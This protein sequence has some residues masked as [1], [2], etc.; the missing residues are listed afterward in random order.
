MTDIF[1][2]VIIEKTADKAKAF[3]SV[4]MSMGQMVEDVKL[5]V[6]GKAKVDFYG[7]TG[8]VIPLPDEILGKIREVAGGIE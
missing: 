7:R 6:N 4:E 8:G 5:A 3:I 1:C 2:H